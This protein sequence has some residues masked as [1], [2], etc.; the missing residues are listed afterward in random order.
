MNTE[1]S[2]SHTWGFWAPGYYLLT[3]GE[4]PYTV[5]KE[6]GFLLVPVS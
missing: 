3:I 6:T 4:I 5:K 1:T 2:R